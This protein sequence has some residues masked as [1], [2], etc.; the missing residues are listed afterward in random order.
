[1]ESILN[2]AD[3]YGSALPLIALI[4]LWHKISKET[5][6]L[7]W[8]F[9][10][11]IIIFGYSNYLA[12]QAKNNLFLYHLFSIIELTLL[13][14]YFKKI[15]DK[16]TVKKIINWLTFSFLAFSILNIL[17]LENLN[18]LN[19]NTQSIEFLV[20]IIFCFIYYNELAKTDEIVIF[21]RQP[22]FWI[23]TGFF[24]YFSC[25]TIIFSFYKYA[26]RYDKPFTS[27]FWVIQELMYLI[28]N[29]FI[30][31]GILCFRKAK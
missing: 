15:I 3:T 22:V 17:L 28:K 10:A 27:G 26:I 14:Q 12:D 4:V 7:F 11:S 9:I 8:Y 25:T 23:V 18:Y 2:Y 31:Y 5:F 24:I 1:M 21:Y 20:L 6:I 30:T 16:K 19:S 13:L 29:I